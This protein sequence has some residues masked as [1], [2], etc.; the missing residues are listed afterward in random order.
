M[1]QS[2]RAQVR[3]TPIQ[4]IDEILDAQKRFEAAVAKAQD[5]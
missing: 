3:G 1:A 2:L 4:E 5:S